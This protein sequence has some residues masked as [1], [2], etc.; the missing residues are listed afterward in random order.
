MDLGQYVVGP[1]QSQAWLWNVGF[2]RSTQRLLDWAPAEEIRPR[3][4]CGGFR[5]NV[6]DTRMA[7]DGIPI[8]SVGGSVRDSMA[9]DR[10]R[11]GRSLSYKR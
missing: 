3:I 7:D 2:A 8:G 6:H 9:E 10:R 4:R 5:R 1:G 11:I